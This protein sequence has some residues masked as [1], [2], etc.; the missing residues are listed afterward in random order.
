MVP[1]NP[2]RHF[3]LQT[4]SYALNMLPTTNSTLHLVVYGENSVDL[5]VGKGK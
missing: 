2:T 1:L 4:T 5:R 3:V